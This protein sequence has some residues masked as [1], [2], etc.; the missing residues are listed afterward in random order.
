MKLKI[1]VNLISLI[2][3]IFNVCKVISSENKVLLVIPGLGNNENRTKITIQ[4]LKQLEIIKTK[5]KQNEKQR[6]SSKI[7]LDCFIFVYKTML[8][9]YESLLKSVCELEYFY[10]GN[11]AYYMKSITPM[12]LKELGYT[13][14]FILL[15][16]VELSANF[17]YYLNIF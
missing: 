11:Y 16:D 1:A 4:N 15:D 3:L 12:F 9:E 2:I 13:H 14:V 7:P 17:R 10:H 6:E 5:T 8:K